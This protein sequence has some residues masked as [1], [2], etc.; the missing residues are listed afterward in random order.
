[1]N[2]QSSC[3]SAVTRAH[4]SC[5]L[6]AA[7]CYS[8]AV[9][10]FKQCAAIRPALFHQVQVPY[11]FSSVQPSQHMCQHLKH[12]EYMQV[13]VATSHCV[14]LAASDGA[15][16]QVMVTDTTSYHVSLHLGWVWERMQSQVPCTL[17]S[18]R[19]GMLLYKWEA[20]L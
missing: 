10:D 4:A 1:M 9:R 8:P 7:K 15:P 17:S 11:V 18:H 5:S 19:T 6:P 12:D 3:A 16:L 20:G 2:G 14:H 13:V